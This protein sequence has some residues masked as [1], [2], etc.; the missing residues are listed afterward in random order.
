MKRLLLIFLATFMFSCSHSSR[1]LQSVDEP[2]LEAIY[3]TWMDFKNTIQFVVKSNGCTN[4][5]SFKLRKT[6]FKGKY[7]LKLKRL[8]EDKCKRLPHP[9][10]IKFDLS[11]YGIPKRAGLIILN[12]FENRP[13][14]LID[15]LDL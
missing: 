1:E 11:A 10:V 2:N 9:K 8:K 3:A 5:K 4:E 7:L 14:F 12:K 13:R 6:L 15:D